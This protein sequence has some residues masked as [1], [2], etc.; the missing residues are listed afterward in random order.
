MSRTWGGTRTY[1]PL[2]WAFTL[3]AALS[4]MGLPPFPGFWSKDAV[5]L[6]AVEASL[7]LFVLALVTA[8]ITAFYTVRFLGMVFHGEATPHLRQMVGSG[9]HL[10]DGATSMRLACGVLA[11]A[12]IAAGLGGPLVEG[13]LH[14]AFEADSSV[15]AHVSTVPAG[16]GGGAHGLVPIP[17]GSVRRPGSG[18][19]LLPV[20]GPQDLA[21][22]LAREQ[23][24]SQVASCLRVAALVS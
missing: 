16:A 19:G 11:V 12:I 8:A 20:R 1:L 4:L 22:G 6:V 18:T 10:D 5:L 23:R 13:V 17:L 9:D 3:V 21:A 2:T 15:G 14:H 24:P 7:P